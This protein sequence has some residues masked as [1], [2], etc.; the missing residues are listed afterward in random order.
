MSF[1]DIVLKAI[2]TPE[3]VAEFDRLAGTN[4]QKKGS[5]LDRMIDDATGRNSDELEMFVSFVFGCIWLPLVEESD[6][7]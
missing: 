3:L 7:F 2:E 1:E 6:R 4:L 5:P